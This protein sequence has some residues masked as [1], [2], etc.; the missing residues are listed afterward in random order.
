MLLAQAVG[1]QAAS[2]TVEAL[3]PNTVVLKINGTRKTLRAGD[4]YEGVKLIS[5]DATV[6]LLEINGERRQLGLH[7]NITTSYQA[8]EQRRLDI[9]RNERMQYITTALINGNSVQVIVDT[10][11]NVVAI[12]SGQAAA[13]G[14]N[15]KETG[16][17]SKLETAS[18]L[19]DAWTV[20]LASVEV[21]GIRVENVRASIIEG[22]YPSTPLLGMTYLQHVELRESNGVLS[23]SRSW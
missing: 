16:S 12:N 2:V 4:S 15:Y 21:G 6:A 19:V 3:L 5:A 23:L 8:P 22:G 1:V 7:R 18:S 9:P 14:I 20:N 13:M 10:G 17:P 11:A